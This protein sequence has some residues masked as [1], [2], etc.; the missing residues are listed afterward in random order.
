MLG[1]VR[2]T[3]IGAEYHPRA[4]LGA[5]FRATVMNPE[6]GFLVPGVGVSK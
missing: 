4:M 3:V 6:D 2:A 5:T 1:E